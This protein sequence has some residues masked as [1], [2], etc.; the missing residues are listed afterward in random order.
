M[1]E[2]IYTVDLFYDRPIEGI[3]NFK[4][5][6]HHFKCEFDDDADEYGGVYRLTPISAETLR[7]AIERWEIWLEWI[8]AFRA[9]EASLDTHPALSRDLVR[10]NELQ[11]AVGQAI[12]DA[13]IGS[14]RARAQFLPDETVEWTKVTS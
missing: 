1:S 2:P 4:G 12:K 9:G 5:D 14:L 7:L 6:P 3:A 10:Y 11:E 13:R 8:A